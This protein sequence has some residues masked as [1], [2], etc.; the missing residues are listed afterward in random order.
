MPS[1]IALL[2]KYAF[3]AEDI[4]L[5][6]AY[7]ELPCD[8]PGREKSL[9]PQPLEATLEP[10]THPELCDSF[11]VERFSEPTAVSE[12]VEVC[13][14]FAIGHALEQVVQLLDHLG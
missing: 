7:T 1:A 3:T 5:L 9:R 4:C 13:G 12:R 6:G 11:G 2:M 10:G 14:G 8:F